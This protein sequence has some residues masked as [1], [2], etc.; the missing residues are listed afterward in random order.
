MTQMREAS[1]LALVA[2]LDGP[3]H[4]Y[5]ILRRVKEL[6]GHT[7]L[8]V[9]ALY[10]G[11]DGL[12]DQ[13]LAV[14]SGSEVVSGRLRQYFEITDEGTGAVQREAERM[15]VAA[16]AGI[17]AAKARASRQRKEQALRS[18]SRRLGATMAIS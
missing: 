2:L 13:G 18:P 5:A 17:K 11:L 15:S 16:A 3:A 9:G 1:Y 8:T 12:V 7:R 10:S 14:R 6:S 4:G